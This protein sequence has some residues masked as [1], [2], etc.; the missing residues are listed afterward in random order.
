MEDFIKFE[1]KQPEPLTKVEVKFSGQIVEAYWGVVNIIDDRVVTAWSLD[2]T[3]GVMPMW[4]R[5]IAAE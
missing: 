3:G 4:W 2:P 1:D 5:P